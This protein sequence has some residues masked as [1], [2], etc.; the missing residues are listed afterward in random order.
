MNWDQENTRRCSIS[1]QKSSIGS[2]AGGG[3]T[4]TPPPPNTC[5]DPA[6]LNF[7]G[8]LPCVYPPPPVQTL[9][10]RPPSALIPILG[11][12]QYNAI[13][14]TGQSESVL[15]AGVHWAL[16]QQI[17]VIGASSGNCTGTSP[18]IA[19]VSAAWQNLIGYAQLEVMANADECAGKKVDIMIAIDTSKSM[20]QSFGQGWSSK[21]IYAKSLAADFVG[22]VNYR[23]GDRVGITSFNETASVVC[24]LSGEQTFIEAQLSGVFVTELKTNLAAGVTAAV[25]QL[26]NADINVLILMTDGL[27]TSLSAQT[28]DSLR[29]AL[30]GKNVMVIVVAIRSYGLA[31]TTL[32]S[33]SEG[34]YLLSAY[35]D[36]GALVE[37]WLQGLKG[38]F[39]AGNCLPDGDVY[40]SHGALNIESL[41][42]WYITG[43][44]DLIGKGSL[45]WTTFDLIPGHGLYLDLVGSSAPWAGR[46]VSRDSFTLESGKTYKLS[47]KLSGN[48]RTERTGFSVKFGLGAEYELTSRVV[49]LDNARQSFTEYSLTV[50][51]DGGQY[52]IRIEQFTRPEI[53]GSSQDVS[54]GNLLDDVKLVRVNNDLSETVLFADDF[55]N[56]NNVY[57]YSVCN[58]PPP[59]ADTKNIS[60]QFH[61]DISHFPQTGVAYIFG[62]GYVRGKAGD[63]W[64]HFETAMLETGQPLIDVAGNTVSGASIKTEAGSFESVEPSGT[65]AGEDTLCKQAIYGLRAG[66]I[67]GPLDWPNL[68]LGPLPEGLYDVYVWGYNL[69]VAV[70]TE[71]YGFIQH[72]DQYQVYLRDYSVLFFP[73]I[74]VRPSGEQYTGKLF[75]ALMDIP[76]E[77][78]T[79][80]NGKF[81]GISGIQLI[82]KGPPMEAGLDG[83]SYDPY[84][85]NCYGD[86]CLNTPPP[87]QRPDPSPIIQDIEGGGVVVVGGGGNGPALPPSISR[88]SVTN[89]RTLIHISRVNNI[90]HYNLYWRRSQG[91]SWTL[92]VTDIAQT[93]DPN[94]QTV[95]AAAI[96]LLPMQFV[97]TSVDSNGV[98]SEYSNMIQR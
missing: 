85:Y 47:C 48:Q 76:Q 45:G 61:N 84:N 94:G 7:G 2:G 19:T 6:A 17:G 43:K 29:A 50:T 51:G 87:E 92:Y 4:I 77:G 31:Y 44:V 62:L 41:S 71:E 86:G 54:Y 46:I 14:H 24:D 78:W 96:P 68:E 9:E 79:P 69:D 35:P 34:G 20:L 97:A 42:N 75:I 11:N 56:E 91:Y 59:P 39:C 38:Y 15:T 60:I 72:W 1:P 66:G 90:H 3:G 18:G 28:I 26:G 81:C 67:G 32:L 23:K 22:K 55:D 13:L 36:T 70:L 49:E 74:R 53:T 65:R 25:S 57:H 93:D 52:P 83:Y 73:N 89:D 12:V 40:E 82:S 58:P 98:E 5:Q 95:S 64:N 10:V 21:F 37:V 27:D 63:Q 88:E 33:F 16:S 80:T 8:Q 30:A